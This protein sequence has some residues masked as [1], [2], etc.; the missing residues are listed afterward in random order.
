MATATRTR[1]TVPATL[2][3]DYNPKTGEVTIVNFTADVDLDSNH[4]APVKRGRRATENPYME[5]Y[6]ESL[7]DGERKVI[8]DA[9]PDDFNMI[10]QFLY[11]AAK[12]H[13]AGVD[14]LADPTLGE[15]SFRARVKRARNR[16]KK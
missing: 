10:K 13:D 15:V 8:T 9:D 5:A 2:E 1:L 14:I 11:R 3:I 7:N 16:T 4:S 12:S 6:T